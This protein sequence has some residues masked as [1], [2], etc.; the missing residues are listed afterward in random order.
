MEN[1][2]FAA[3]HRT[4]RDLQSDILR[5][6]IALIFQT[7][8]PGVRLDRNPLIFSLVPLLSA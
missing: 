5:L 6:E 4:D 3:N 2:Q 1:E 7:H 8:S